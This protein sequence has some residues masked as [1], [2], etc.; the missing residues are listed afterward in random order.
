MPEAGGPSV[1]AG[2]FLV[3]MASSAQKNWNSLQNQGRGFRGAGVLKIFRQKK[4][5]QQT[6]IER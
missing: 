3:S 4:M 2:S 6:R 1:L 5:T